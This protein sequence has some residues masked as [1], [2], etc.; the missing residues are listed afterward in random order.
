[1]AF[2]C[3]FHYSSVHWEAL[4]IKWKFTRSNRN[5][6]PSLSRI[7]RCFIHQMLWNSVSFLDKSFNKVFAIFEEDSVCQNAIFCSTDTCVLIINQMTKLVILAKRCHLVSERENGINCVRDC[8]Q[9]FSSKSLI[10][11]F[12][13]Y[14]ALKKK[15]IIL[16][17]KECKS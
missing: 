6:W 7:H 15:C 13:L 5:V 9:S 16:F 12:Q 11:T 4:P 8:L 17:G 3:I 1:M 2:D 10:P 14:S